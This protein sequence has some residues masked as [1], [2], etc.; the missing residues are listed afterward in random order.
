MMDENKVLNLDEMFGEDR[1]VKVKWKG[2]EYELLRLEAFSPREINRFQTMQK[3]ASELQRLKNANAADKSI[4]AKIEQLFDKMLS[5]LCAKLPLKEIPFLGKTRI[6]TFYI[7]E[8][9]GKKAL[10]VA[11]TQQVTGATSLAA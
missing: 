4:D 7:E 10:E 3:D 8:T 2:V 5:T 1:P 11:L 6:I 9:Q